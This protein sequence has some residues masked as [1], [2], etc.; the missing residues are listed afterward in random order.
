[1]GSRSAILASHFAEVLR[2]TVPSRQTDSLPSAAD[3]DVYHRAMRLPMATPPTMM[4]SS[5][6]APNRKPMDKKKLSVTP[7]GLSDEEAADEGKCNACECG[8]HRGQTGR[9]GVTV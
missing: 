2:L 9:G 1:M 6:A 7:T 3:P 4:P 8:R 5:P